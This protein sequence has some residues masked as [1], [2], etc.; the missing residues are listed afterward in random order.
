MHEEEGLTP[1]EQELELALGKLKPAA[2]TLNRDDLMF[3]AGLAA[4]GGKRHWQMF[5]GVLTLLLLCSVLI[6]P[7]LRRTEGFP[8]PGDTGG[9][10]MAQAVY[11]PVQIE[12][13]GSFAYPKL[14]Q[15]IVRYGLDALPL[16]Q[17]LSRGAQQKSRKQLLESMLSS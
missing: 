5:S 15:S 8:S 1:A 14:R 13:P 16:R 6:R 4:A 17:G 7:E 9:F 10:Q 12:P 2:N 11:V 3:N